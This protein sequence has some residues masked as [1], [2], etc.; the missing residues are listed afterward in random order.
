MSTEFTLQVTG[1]C[2]VG[3]PA[4][5]Q[6]RL[7]IPFIGEHLSI[8]AAAAVAV[9]S[10]V[11]NA[12]GNIT[13][14]RCIPNNQHALSEML[15]GSWLK[16]WQP[17]RGRLQILPIQCGFIIDDSYNA[18]PASVM[19]A[20]KVLSGIRAP[21]GETLTKVVLLGDMNELGAQ[22][23][24]LH[25][26][27]LVYLGMQSSMHVGLLGP[28]MRNAWVTL[29]GEP[30]EFSHL[31]HWKSGISH[32]LIQPDPALAALLSAEVAEWM[33]TRSKTTRVIT[34][35]KGSRHMQMERM[36]INLKLA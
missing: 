29:H 13:R 27:V 20:L 21:D 34:L 16:D 23:A 28:R 15:S 4:F 5:S 36:L 30:D 18:N 1:G 32:A 33:G 2:D 31:S 6:A 35:I 9:A 12:S 25:E 8:N 19:H 7:C 14:R 17:I 24:Q 26:R 10:A 3:K 11:V 22:S